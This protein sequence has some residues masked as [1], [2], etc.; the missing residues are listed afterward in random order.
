M[1]AG[2]TTTVAQGGLGS[3]RTLER[4]PAIVGCSSSGT[5]YTPT[6]ISSAEDAVAA[7]GYGKLV[8]LIALYIALAGG[9]VIAVRATTATAGSA[10]SVTAAGTGTAVMTVATSTSRD[11]YFVKILVTRAGA[12]LAAATAAVK[13]SYDGGTTYGGEIAVPTSGSLTLG[14]SGLAV[15]WADGT[16]VV[17]D[18]Y[19]FSATAP[20][21]DTTN[22]GLALDSLEATSHDHEFVHVA[23]HVTGATVGTLD[24]SLSSLEAAGV[25]RWWLATARG[26]N[27]GESVSTWQGVLIGGSPGFS[28]FTSRHGIVFAGVAAV[29]AYGVS[30]TLRRQV[31]WLVGPRL[32]RLRAVSGGAGLAEH[33][34]RVRS[35]AIEGG[36]ANG[37]VHDLRTLT[38]LDAHRFAGLQSIQGRSGYYATARTAAEDGS[39]FATV[40]NIRVVKEA[41]RIA[42]LA[43]TEFLNDNVRTITG[44][45]LDPRD[46]DAIDAYVTQQMV[47]GM[48]NTGYA[49]AAS[50]QVNRT[51]NILS[52]SD[53]RFK[54][55]VRPLGYATTIELSIGL[56]AE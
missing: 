47:A 34:G 42:N 44:G 49:S 48:V 53:L 11:D 45:L 6:L 5:P 39:D 20:I 51:D 55:R 3:V 1:I 8:E 37:L 30:A 52:T 17:G 50:A 2:I 10:T 41:A 33:P 54:V 19:S 4:P 7:F 36:A 21:W 13:V 14:N 40:M 23:E 38:T 18:T 9:P 22:L 31:G 16:F 12:D 29:P 43:A 46:A 25:F 15:E 32:A 35:G 27:S 56:S 28:G 26:Q 24:T